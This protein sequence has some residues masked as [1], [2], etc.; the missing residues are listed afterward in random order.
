M[1]PLFRSTQAVRSLFLMVLAVAC[2]RSAVAAPSDS[3]SVAR[4]S[5]DDPWDVNVPHA[6]SDTLRFQTDRGTWMSVDVSPDR[7]AVRG[8][9]SVDISAAALPTGGRVSASGSIQIGVEPGFALC[10]RPQHRERHNDS[11]GGLGG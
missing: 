7:P 5:S 1:P 10:V 8:Q 2:A 9:F 11:F 6:A 3:T 4:P